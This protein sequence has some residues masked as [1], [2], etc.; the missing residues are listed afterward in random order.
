MRWGLVGLLVAGCGVVADIKDR[1]EGVLDRVVAIGVITVLEPP[2]DD[3]IDLSSLDL[4]LGIAATAFLADA[5]SVA[6]IENAPIAGQII[7][8]SGCGR[9]ARLTDEGDGSYLLLPPS[10]LDD[11]EGPEFVLTRLD[12]TEPTVLPVTLPPAADLDVPTTWNGGA[13]LV[14]D[15]SAA[16]FDSVLVVVLDATTGDVAFSNEPQGVGEWYRFLTGSGDATSVTVPGSAFV[17]DALYAV[18]VTGLVRTPNTE[19]ERANEL[20]SVVVGGRA[21]A[22]ALSTYDELDT[23]QWGP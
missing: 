7:E 9:T 3:R 1:V 11:C 10:E 16:G 23:G 6:D 17:D 12:D 4:Q 5:G 22:Y 15:L 14:L 19:L 13:D 8:A 20:L 2:E 18:T 21:R